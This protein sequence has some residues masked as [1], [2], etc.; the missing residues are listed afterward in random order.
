[1]HEVIFGYQLRVMPQRRGLGVDASLV[2]SADTS[3]WYSADDALL[4][5]MFFTNAGE[6][7]FREPNGL[8]AYRLRENL[9]PQMYQDRHDALLIAL[10]ASQPVFEQLS[11]SRGV[12]FD[13][14][15][16]DADFA[17]DWGSLG[18]DVT[19]GWLVSG[20]HNCN[21]ETRSE[22]VD[23]SI[24]QNINTFGLLHDFSAA[25]QFCDVCNLHISEHAPFMPIGLWARK[26]QIKQLAL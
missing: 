17:K 3:V 24:K 5:Q 6:E 21:W 13:R 15:C 16:S 12:E 11:Q 18:Y 8:L 7:A 4:R 2:L 22:D 1:M 23:Q 19:D 9:S 26:E 10:S 25:A 20:L 14:N